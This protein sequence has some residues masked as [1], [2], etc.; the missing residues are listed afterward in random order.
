M[1]KDQ[2]RYLLSLYLVG[3]LTDNQRKEL[4]TLLGDERA[5]LL[6]D[7]LMPARRRRRGRAGEAGG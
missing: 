6:L 7:E 2:L 3:T 4:V 5:A 1:M